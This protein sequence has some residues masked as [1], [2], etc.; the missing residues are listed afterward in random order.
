M[1]TS[2]HLALASI[3]LIPQVAEI[4]DHNYSSPEAA[5]HDYHTCKGRSNSL[6]SLTFVP[7]L[8]FLAMTNS[9]CPWAGG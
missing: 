5:L 4:S 3:P 2:F 6:R 9:A 8:T 1:T 7:H